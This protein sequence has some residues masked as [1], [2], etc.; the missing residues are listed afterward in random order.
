MPK[1]TRMDGKQ[2]RAGG[3]MRRNESYSRDNGVNARG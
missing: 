1:V 2:D 3:R